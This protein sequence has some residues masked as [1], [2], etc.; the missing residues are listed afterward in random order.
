MSRTRDPEV[1]EEWRPVVGYE[2]WYEVSNLGRVRRVRPESATWAGRILAS[3]PDSWGYPKV[4]LHKEGRPATRQVHCLVA[5]AFLGPRP[6]GMEVNH[7]NGRKHDPS[8]K[9]L[10]YT[11]PSGN[12][13]HA[14]AAGLRVPLRG[15]QNAKARLNDGQVL[16]IDQMLRR[17]V[18]HKDIAPLFG[19]STNTVKWIGNGETWSHVT[20]R[21]KK[22]RPK[23]RRLEERKVSAFDGQGDHPGQQEQADNGN[24]NPKAD[25]TPTRRDDSVRP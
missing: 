14:L 24:S 3:S 21:P 22:N 1:V 17:G 7:I 23:T 11:T 16:E 9:E 19:I 15:E 20:G 13:M 4:Q 18:R 5:A 10:E 12:T 2:G 8:L 6:E 25:A